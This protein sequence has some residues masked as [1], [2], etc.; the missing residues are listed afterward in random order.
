MILGITTDMLGE[1]TTVTLK[2]NCMD[3][4]V[5]SVLNEDIQ[6][7]STSCKLKII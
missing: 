2:H 7:T 1:S 5:K 6:Y 3:I 4:D